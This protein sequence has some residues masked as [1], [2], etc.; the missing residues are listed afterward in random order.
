MRYV[1][2]IFTGLFYLYNRKSK[3]HN[4]QKAYQTTFNKANTLK[5]SK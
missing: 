4:N 1:A 5:Q 2:N 3:K